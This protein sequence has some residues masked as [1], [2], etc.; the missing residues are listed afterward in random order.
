MISEDN[1]VQRLGAITERLRELA[2]LLAPGYAAVS[3]LETE[4]NGIDV[5]VIESHPVFGPLWKEERT[6]RDELVLIQIKLGLAWERNQ[7]SS[8]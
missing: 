7:G 4:E 1:P 8:S 3:L 6:L 5:E 2:R